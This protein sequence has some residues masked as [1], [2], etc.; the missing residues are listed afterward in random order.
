MKRLAVRR[1]P[2]KLIMAAII[3]SCG[4]AMS[5]EP[6]VRAKGKGQEAKPARSDE[7]RPRQL[8][9]HPARVKQTAS[10]RIYPSSR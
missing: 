9:P 3:L 10:A 5:N 1:F 7:V 2:E 6:N 8:P 4:L